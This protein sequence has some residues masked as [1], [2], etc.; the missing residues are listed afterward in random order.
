VAQYKSALSLGAT[1]PL[2][3]IYAAMGARTVF[4]AATMKELM[5]LVEENVHQLRQMIASGDAA[6]R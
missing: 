5:D 1:R 6:T 2:G 4:D 3:D